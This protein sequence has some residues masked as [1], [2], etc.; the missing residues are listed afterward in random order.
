MRKVA[1]I[2]LAVICEKARRLYFIFRVTKEL[3]E[4]LV[5]K[6]L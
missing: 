6:E 4:L 1:I 2:I 5:E 3:L